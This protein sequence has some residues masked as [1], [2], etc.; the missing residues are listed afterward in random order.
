[1]CENKCTKEQ[2]AAKVF[3][4]DDEEDIK[5]NGNSEFDILKKFNHPNVLMVNEAYIWYDS[6]KAKFYF[7]IIMELC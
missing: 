2:F 5:L 3:Y 7:A 6:K 1:M 4:S